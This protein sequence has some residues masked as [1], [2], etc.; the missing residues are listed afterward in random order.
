MSNRLRKANRKIEANVEI[1]IRSSQL[2]T[3][4]KVAQRLSHQRQYAAEHFQ[5]RNPNGQQVL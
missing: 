3:F 2:R 4:R 5:S 1:I